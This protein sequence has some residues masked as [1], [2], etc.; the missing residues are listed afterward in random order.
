MA[1][2]KPIHV[3]IDTNWFVSATVNKASRR[4]L[5]N[6]FIDSN[7]RVFYCQELLDE[8]RVVIRRKKFSQAIT[9]Q[10]S[11]RL[12]RLCRK[13]MIKIPVKKKVVA[14]RDPKD[15]YL[16]SLADECKAAYLITGDNDLLSLKSYHSTRMVP[17]T[18]FLNILKR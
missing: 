15:N 5:Y 13:R 8:Y 7:I 17:L 11:E 10:Q 2:A 16:L 18:E 14:S 9:S 3:V 12:I 1:K 6:L 4:K